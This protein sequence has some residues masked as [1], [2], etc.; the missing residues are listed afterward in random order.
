GLASL[1]LDLQPIAVVYGNGLFPVV[2]IQVAY[3][4]T[5]GVVLGRAVQRAGLESEVRSL[6]N[7]GPTVHIVDLDDRMQLVLGVDGQ[8]FVAAVTPPAML[9]DTL[10]LLA[11]GP[12]ESLADTGTL[13]A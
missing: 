6:P 3:A 1:G 10:A 4:D 12:T 8:S 5:V 9:D 2:R 11:D 13:E 7:G